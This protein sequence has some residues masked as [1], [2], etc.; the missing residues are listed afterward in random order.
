MANW[1]Y[2][3]GG[4]TVGPL[5]PAE[6]KG[7]VADGTVDAATRVRR[8]EDGEWLTADRVPGLIRRA[9]EYGESVYAAPAA[10]EGDATGGLIPYKNSPALIGYYLAV[11][12]LIPCLGMP[13]GIA[14]VVCGVLG[15]KK[16]REN[17]AVKG[18]AHAWVGIVL[19]G[20]TTLV[21]GGSII[22]MI[23]GAAANA[24]G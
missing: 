8:D 1:Y 7:L 10:S 14:A 12:S 3:D 17:P 21:W 11:F 20:L 18:T 2:G 24:N 22:A 9:D 5:T 13:L 15:L 6:M 23:V 4:H 19:G 16:R